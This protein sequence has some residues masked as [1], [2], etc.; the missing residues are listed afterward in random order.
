MMNII[1]EPE[2]IIEE[3]I[4]QLNIKEE[5]KRIVLEIFEWVKRMNEKYG[6]VVTSVLGVK[7]D[8]G[9]A[10]CREQ[11]GTDWKNYMASN[12]IYLPTQEDLDRALEW[13]NGNIPN[14][15]KL[16]QCF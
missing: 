16:K 12:N 7:Y 15:V 14:W 9:Q 3:A 13:E 1:E 10:L 11:F 5:Q 6:L 2:E 8:W 4:D